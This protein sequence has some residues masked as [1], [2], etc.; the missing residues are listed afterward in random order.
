[1]SKLLTQDSHP[2]M[3]SSAPSIDGLLAALKKIR[4]EVADFA[5]QWDD[6]TKEYVGM[7]FSDTLF[8]DATDNIFYG[9]V[10]GKDRFHP[11]LGWQIDV[12]FMHNGSQVQFSIGSKQYRNDPTKE[13][14]NFEVPVTIP[15]IMIHLFYKAIDKIATELA[16]GII[17]NS[18]L[19]PHHWSHIY[20]AIP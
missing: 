19:P 4:R 14:I 11:E 8:D 7:F 18:A 13:D 6:P 3:I 10:V 20:R 1:M 5:K 15:V 2:L 9:I 16:N 17:D 12:T